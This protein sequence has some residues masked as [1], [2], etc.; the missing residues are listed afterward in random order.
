VVLY[1]PYQIHRSFNLGQSFLPPLIS[2]SLFN[3]LI[4]PFL[5]YHLFHE[6][7]LKQLEKEKKNIEAQI[8]ELLISVKIT[9]E[10]MKMC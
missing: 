4:F 7:E 2:L 10:K 1:H 6:R 3:P 9:K 8:E 5:S